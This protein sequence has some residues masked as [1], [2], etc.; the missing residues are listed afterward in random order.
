[1]QSI[2]AAERFLLPIL[3]L[4]ALILIFIG[5]PDQYD[6][7]SYQYAW[8]AGHVISFFLW[9]YLCLHYLHKLRCIDFLK[10]I[11]LFVIIAFVLGVVIEFMQ[12]QIGRDYSWN[13]V[14]NDILGSALAVSLLSTQ[15]THINQTI[16]RLLVSSLIIAITI[17]NKDLAIVLIDDYQAREQFPVLADFSAPFAASRWQGD[18]RIQIISDDRLSATNILK[19]E[20]NTHRY[21]GVILQH[22]PT[23]WST[24]SQLQIDYYNPASEAL[25][26]TCRIHDKQHEK[27]EQRYDDRFNRQIVLQPGWHSLQIKLEDVI[28]APAQRQMDIG[29]MMAIG[30][31]ATQLHHEQAFFIGN[32]Q[33]IRE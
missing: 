30:L 12:S 26:L 24:F 4:L 1:M 2:R 20:L 23:D 18:S 16:R 19:V 29:D 3:A 8:N 25:V 5:G 13:D 15:R 9:T 33:L 21:S 32:V 22:F 27:G 28:N 31:F 7:R 10:Q 6:P 11:S 14:I 17:H